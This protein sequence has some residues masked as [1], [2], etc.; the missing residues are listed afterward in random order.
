M[1][2]QAIAKARAGGGFGSVADPYD[3]EDEEESSSSSLDLEQVRALRSSWRFDARQGCRRH[4]LDALSVMSAILQLQ[5]LGDRRWMTCWL[6][7]LRLPRG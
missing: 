6:E 4:P 5:E 7:L 3:E 2:T 1:L